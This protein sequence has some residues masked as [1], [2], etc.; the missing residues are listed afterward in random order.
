[1]PGL[2]H[3]RL[4]PEAVIKIV[5]CSFHAAGER[6]PRVS[7]EYKRPVLIGTVFLARQFRHQRIPETHPDPE[8]LLCHR[9]FLKRIVQQ[10][11]PDTLL[12]GCLYI[13][14]RTWRQVIIALI[15]RYHDTAHIDRPGRDRLADQVR[16]VDIQLHIKAIILIVQ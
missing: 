1:M 2:H 6:N 16:S 15:V 3:I 5:V 4:Q 8:I 11:H 10:P 9:D 12:L 7:L 14:H 13:R